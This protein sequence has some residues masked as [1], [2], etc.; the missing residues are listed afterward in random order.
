M[1][2][3]SVDAAFLNGSTDSV[4]NPKASYNPNGVTLY[5]KGGVGF[6]FNGNSPTFMD[7]SNN[8]SSDYQGYLMIVE[9]T[10]TSHQSCTM[11]GGANLDVNGLF[12][13]PYCDFTINGQAGETAAFNAQLIGWDI[14]INGSNAINFNYDPSNQVKIKRKIGLMK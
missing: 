4:K 5:L 6:T 2:W 9:G 1:S 11:N 14:K 8:P 10:P 3:S 12:F 13:A 7:A